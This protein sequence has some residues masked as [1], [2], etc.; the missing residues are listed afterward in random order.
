VL[1]TSRPHL[2]CSQRLELESIAAL[3]ALEHE[4]TALVTAVVA[5]L[6]GFVFASPLK[7]ALICVA[8]KL[9]KARQG[10][11]RQ[12]RL[13]GRLKNFAFGTRFAWFSYC[14]CCNYAR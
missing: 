2:A 4:C 6:A 7:I 13:R 8:S 11:A 14:T 10:K 9:G 5:I 1:C 3:N 12:G